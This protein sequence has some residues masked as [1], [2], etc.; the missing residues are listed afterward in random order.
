MENGIKKKQKGL[1]KKIFGL[2]VTII[3]VAIVVFAV[4]GIM[5]LRLIFRMASETGKSQTV[6]IKDKSRETLTEIMESS[7]NQTIRQA[8]SSTDNE[9]W[10]MRHDFTILSLQVQDVFLHPENYAEIE[11][12]PPKKENGGEYVAQLLFAD[13]A[14]QEDEET[15]T[16]M[17]KLANLAPSMAEIIRG[18]SDYTMDC[19][20]ALPSGATLAMDNMS[21]RKFEED[22][23]I[24]P[25]DATTRA[26]YQGAVAD[27][28]MYFSPAIH[29]Y[30]YDLTEVV[31]GVPVYVDGELVAVLE[32]S[33]KLD[34]LQKM[35]SEL[36]Y[37][38]SGFSILVTGEGQ[39]VYSPRTS[40]DLAM[41]SDISQTGNAELKALVD[42]A[43]AMEQ[44]FTS[45]TVDGEKTYVAY[46]PIK[47]L[48][49][50]Q[51]MFVPESELERPSDIL[52]EEM[53][54]VTM[55]T[56]SSFSG[57]FKNFLVIT[58]LALMLLVAN[59]AFMALV[60]SKKLVTPIQIM[61]KGV[62]DIDGENMSF[63]MQS[64]YETGDEIE[65]L[66]NAFHKLTGK[67]NDYIVEI[68]R[69]S[70]EKERIDTE[71]ATA[72]Q[73]QD[74]MLPKIFPAFPEREEFELYADMKPAKEVGG[75]LY[76]YYF[77][78]DDRL[79]IVI[80]DVSGKGIS[81]ALFMVM[82]KHIIQSQVMLH[83][84]DV[85]KAL[86]GV[87]TVLMEENA[88]GMFVTVWL[89]VLEVSSGR[90]NYINAGHEYPIIYRNGEEFKL[91]K[92][93]HGAPVACSKN[94]RLKPNEIVMKP[95]DVLYLYTDGI[96]EASDK[97]LNM[98][99]QDRIIDVL[100]SGENRTVDEMDKA[101]RAAISDFAGDAEQFD[102][103][104]SLII[105]YHGPKQ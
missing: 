19:Y 39:L 54:A 104:T 48:G 56:L 83:N 37:G 95:G 34:S 16:M 82:T 58:V 25:Y 15:L 28:E 77:I 65:T 3:T 94:I 67:I 32:G 75:D 61:T 17:G 62:K 36:N 26:W 45:V 12:D 96:T 100:N 79:T 64:E 51:M 74:S 30:F 90:I 44:G 53:D 97:D 63:E 10:T 18:N 76:D 41:S 55:D 99:G 89:G 87:N 102:D 6:A 66:A 105:R 23:S 7:L 81:A 78:D 93:N 50:T 38:E 14:D 98:F 71:M 22:G 60:F 47:S 103:M 59:A 52:L 42:K 91:Y 72:K 88:A 86:E 2:C 31:F 69:I 80:G 1:Q 4:I 35:V 40:G 5:Q 68:T 70:A 49:W 92:D 57:K 85:V 13:W 24:R 46:A 20:I 73:I 43:L 33:T 101:V 84:G 8:A 27:H 9:F 21:D 11:I 29:S